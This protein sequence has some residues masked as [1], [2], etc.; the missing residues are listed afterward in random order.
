[1]ASIN[2]VL[3]ACSLHL[4]APGKPGADLEAAWLPGR[5]DARAALNEAAKLLCVRLRKMYRK[6]HR[7]TSM[8]EVS[9]SVTGGKQGTSRHAR[10]YYHATLSP[11]ILSL[12]LKS[13]AMRPIHRPMRHLNR[14]MRHYQPV[15]RR[16]SEQPSQLAGLVLSDTT[17]V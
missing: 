8:F 14:R 5:T 1:M 17:R 11:P 6:L 2:R 10:R 9:R 13:L 12:T 3:P 15:R 16:R 4:R 7:A